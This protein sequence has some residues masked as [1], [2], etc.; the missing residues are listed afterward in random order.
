MFGFFTLT[1]T[2][3]S[4]PQRSRIVFSDT[5]LALHYSATEFTIEAYSAFTDVDAGHKED[6][7]NAKRFTYGRRI[8]RRAKL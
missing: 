7:R 4:K 5:P 8:G 3:N 6:M 2:K 1:F